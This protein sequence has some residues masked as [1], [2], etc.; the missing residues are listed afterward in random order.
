MKINKLNYENF[1][2][3]YIEGNLS[4]EQKEAFDFFIVDHPEIYDEIKEF[5]SAPILKEDESIIFENKELLLVDQSKFKYA[6]LLIPVLLVVFC[7]LFFGT[8]E[9]V[10]KVPAEEINKTMPLAQ[11]EPIKEIKE[12]AKINL[13]D[14]L[15]LETKEVVTEIEEQMP[16]ASTTKVIA[17]KTTPIVKKAMVKKAEPRFVKTEIIKAETE[18]AKIDIE[19]IDKEADAE[20]V[21][22]REV[23]TGIASLQTERSDLDIKTET[24]GLNMNFSNKK[25]IEKRDGNWKD[26]KKVFA[27]NA[28]KDVDLRE[29]LSS[30]SVNDFMKERKLLQSFI[31]ET[32]TKK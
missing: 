20:P 3:D 23:I 18:V 19:V 14:N 7:L 28:Y 2:I 21:A 26:L 8:K 15:E 25:I 30:E 32:F 10:N 11:V 27:T 1:V 12:E 24:K 9:Q 22:N 6:W 5:I 4:G 13:S 16:I 17:S 31:P 29:S